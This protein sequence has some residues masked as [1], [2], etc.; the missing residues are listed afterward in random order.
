[1]ACWGERAVYGAERRQ[2]QREKESCEE[3]RLSDRKYVICG[4]S[5]RS[6]HVRA[7]INKQKCHA[8]E[9]VL[10]LYIKQ[11]CCDNPDMT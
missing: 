4:C 9:L 11:T 3:K 1:V 7:L 8:H 10:D 2:R 6:K 5:H